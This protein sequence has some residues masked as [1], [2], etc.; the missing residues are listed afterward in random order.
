MKF[1]D[2]NRISELWQAVKDRVNSLIPSITTAQQIANNASSAATA[3]QQTADSAVTAAETAQDSANIAQEAANNAQSTANAALPKSGGVMTG[4]IQGG[5][6]GS[7]NIT[8]L[9]QPT[10]HKDLFFINKGVNSSYGLQL[11]TAD[12]TFVTQL[13]EEAI[14]RGIADP[15]NINDAA[16]K[17][18]VDN[19]IIHRCIIDNHYFI[20]P[21]NQRNI[22]YNTLWGSNSY[23][24]DRWASSYGNL[25]TLVEN[26]GINLTAG[27]NS[28]IEQRF[29]KERLSTGQSYCF[30]FI[31]NNKLVWF[32]FTW[33]NSNVV[34]SFNDD[35][36]AVIASITIYNDYLLY[37]IWNQSTADIMIP[38]AYLE[39]GSIPTWAVQNGNSV[40]IKEIPDY[41][42]ELLKCQSY[43]YKTPSAQERGISSYSYDTTT[44]FCFDKF[45][46]AMRANPTLSNIA[47][48]NAENGNVVSG[49][50]VVSLSREGIA[51]LSKS[52]SLTQGKYYQLSYEASADL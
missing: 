35:N 32:S 23:G 17:R 5:V 14:L 16:N 47:A 11:G 25:V 45:P 49:L 9:S 52:T 42:T 8:M 12:N 38:A 24:I 40:L 6:N 22:Q 28:I 44:L 46:A 1:L 36:G 20:N 19:A 48:R 51:K 34:H 18:Y 29:E 31:V 3:A 43:Y 41:A 7:D 26:Q 21:I 39:I 37:C 4:A 30:S 50:N 27:S 10:S 33:N 13:S 2:E 15:S